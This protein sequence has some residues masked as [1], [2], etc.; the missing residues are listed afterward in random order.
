MKYFVLI[1]LI[2]TFQASNAESY[3][4]NTD[5]NRQQL[6]DFLKKYKFRPLR[7]ET[8]EITKKY[9]LGQALFF[10]PILSTNNDIS[11][12]TCHLVRLGTS[13]GIDKSIGS[14]GEGIGKGRKEGN[15][16]KRHHRNSLSLWNKDNKTVTS[17][18][19]DGR[20]EVIDPVARDFRSPL[21][22]YSPKSIEN[23][24]ALQALIPLVNTGE[25]F[26]KNCNGKNNC[27][28]PNKASKKDEILK[29]ILEK[30]IG[31][32]NK[33]PQNKVQKKYRRLFNLAYNN[34]ALEDIDYGH[35]GNAIAHFEEIAFAT[36]DSNWDKYIK[37]EE[38]ALSDSQVKGALL[39]YGE[40]GCSVC[41]N[42]PVF[43]DYSFH[44]LG[45]VSYRENEQPDY[46][47][48]DVTKIESDK[49]KFRTPSLRNVTL[50]APYFHDG[51]SNDLKIAI[52]RHY[53]Y[54]DKESYNFSEILVSK[55][56][57]GDKDI[58]Y[59]VS[60]LKALEDSASIYLPFIIPDTVPSGL[61]V[62]AIL[63][64]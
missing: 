18:F 12:A 8:F 40:K 15:I 9:I 35:I 26:S 13:D 34:I 55:N 46:G 24:L 45:I 14:G 27:F 41:H 42:G 4:E 10:D 7:S 62:D 52:K 16:E 37:G 19:L 22:K 25:M 32:T 44:S 50:T 64:K 1:L 59:I 6:R 20:V 39:F 38:E 17:M 61:A 57:L 54:L 28:E 3:S 51:S 58:Y 31:D 47:R 43:S 60:F 5:T 11:C 33:P 21:E 2:V 49:Y 23:L 29:G 30:I 56:S 53:Q 63:K 48:Y 36:R